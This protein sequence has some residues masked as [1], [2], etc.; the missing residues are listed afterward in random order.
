MLQGATFFCACFEQVILLIF[1]KICGGMQL[2][3]LIVG[4]YVEKHNK[5]CIKIELKINLVQSAPL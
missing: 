5:Y 1:E 2:F 3:L 4:S